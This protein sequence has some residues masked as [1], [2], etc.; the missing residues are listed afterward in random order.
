[1][2]IACV[3]FILL[4][5][6]PVKFAVARPLGKQQTSDQQQPASI[7]DAA[8]RTREQRKSHPQVTHSWDNDN[9][10]TNP[11]EV[12]VV[13]SPA[14]PPADENAPSARADKAAGAPASAQKAGAA[15]PS[16]DAAKDAKEEAAVRSEL[17]SAKDRLKILMTDL[18]I[19]SRQYTLDQAQYYSKPDYSS[20][21]DG[22]ER[23]NK[24]QS[25][26]EA[27]RQEVAEAQKKV[28]ELQAKLGPPS[29]PQP[30]QN[31]N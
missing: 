3:G 25:D 29:S 24:E 9:I 22:Q 15:P 19:L 28:D 17:E 12:S 20:D 21:R 2:K 4:L 16:G 7:A 18:D 30:P 27:K 5:A 14:A 6:L 23:V 26:V 1:M 11:N 31:P 10:P 13:G 8:R